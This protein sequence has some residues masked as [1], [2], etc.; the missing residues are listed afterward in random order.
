MDAPPRRVYAFG[1]FTLDLTSGR[2][3]KGTQ[4]IRL[5]P[6]A[7][8]L[9]R[10]FV[11]NGGRLLGKD[12][13]I[14]AVWSGTAVTDDALIKRIKDLR[15]ALGDGDRQRY[16]QTVP[17]RGY[18]FTAEVRETSAELPAPRRLPA[19]PP[20]RRAGWAVLAAAALAAVLVAV[21]APRQRTAVTAP[22]PVR[23]IAVLPLRNLTND[24]AN[25][26]FSEGLTESLTGALSAVETLSVVPR[27]AAVRRARAGMDPRSIGRQLGV[28]AV[29][30]G[31]V[32]KSA[33]SV[34]VAVRLVGVGDGRVL[35]TH[36]TQERAIGDLFA[37]QDEIARSVVGELVGSLEN[38]GEVVAP[39][40]AASVEAYEA[41][42]KGRYVWNKR[43]AESLRQAVVYFEEAIRRDPAYAPAYVGLADTYLVL[44]S[45]TL[46]TPAEARARVER[47]LERALDIDD[48]LGP[49]HTSLAWLRFSYDWNWAGAEQAFLRALQLQP[50]DATTHQWYGEYLAAMGRFDESLAQLRRALQI[51]P[52]SPIINTMAA[53]TLVFSRD[54]D[55][56]IDQC[57]KTL[58]IDGTFYLALDYLAWAYKLKGMHAEAV[59]AVEK[60]HALEN[61]PRSWGEVGIAYAAAGRRADAERAI[62]AVLHSSAREPGPKH[63]YRLARIYA[64]L[65]ERDL[66][67]QWL[68]TAYA[69]R[70]ENLVWLK[71]DPHLDPLRADPRFADLLRRVGFTES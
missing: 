5:R 8:D 64:A 34:R 11:E 71:V 63:S 62:R 60:A 32:R 53:Q 14:A 12:E 41:Y 33:D 45:L 9:L 7:F 19:L 51:D 44:K 65:G 2:L 15:E 50:N 37:L 57:R 17:R 47:A 36:D 66:A 49:A 59:A 46:V 30:E 61:T 6:K 29:L 58:D 10:C 40:H 4:E 26:Y 68:E 3:L 24:P 21:I 27:S 28:A 18:I 56:A 70:E 25:D 23:S 42:L 20:R 39:R 16:I 69:E 13:L 22:G 67:F 38:P 1:D 43:T 54:Y 48:G 52:P 35:W 31:S 55:A